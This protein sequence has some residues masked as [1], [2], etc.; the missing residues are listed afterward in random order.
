MIRNI[1]NLGL[2]QNMDF[3]GSELTRESKMDYE[4][5]GRCLGCK[6]TT[7]AKKTVKKVLC[8]RNCTK[9]QVSTFAELDG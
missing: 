8:P 3:G 6:L 2:Q 1:Q 9:I 4:A 5:S 7:K